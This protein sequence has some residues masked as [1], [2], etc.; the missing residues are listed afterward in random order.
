MTY[1]KNQIGKRLLK[2]RKDNN[3]SMEDFAKLIDMSG[4]STIN[5]WEKGR[6]IPSKKALRNIS[7]ILDIDSNFILY[8]TFSNYVKN[9]IL[10]TIKSRNDEPII[11]TFFDYLTEIDALSRFEFYEKEYPVQTIQ[12][13]IFIKEKILN[14]AIEVTLD[15]NM[16]ELTGFLKNNHFT[17]SSPQ[18]TILNGVNIF[19]LKK[20]NKDNLSIN[21]LIDEL[22]SVTTIDTKSINHI[23]QNDYAKILVATNKF[24]TELLKI[25]VKENHYD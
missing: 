24:H 25:Q 23:S 6:S 7:K 20:T 21:T 9:L 13:Q 17:F 22:I 4:K 3:L 5:E 16:D 1:D 14:T 19:F 8:G 12:D 11:S 15:E 18:H 10:S 2:I